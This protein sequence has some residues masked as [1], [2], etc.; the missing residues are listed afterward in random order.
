MTVNANAAIPLMTAVSLLSGLP[1][2]WCVA[3]H[4]LVRAA[5]QPLLA[6]AVGKL[7]QER[8]LAAGNRRAVQQLDDLLALLLG[9][10]PAA[11]EQE[12]RSQ[13]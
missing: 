4:P 9:L 2:L 3:P 7:D 6:P 1:H 12:S 11:G 5:V 8:L 13:S 10:H